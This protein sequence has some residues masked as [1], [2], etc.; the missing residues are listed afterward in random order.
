[1]RVRSVVG[2]VNH[3]E[4]IPP[5]TMSA[6]ARFWPWTSGHDT[7]EGMTKDDA[8]FQLDA[9]E[10][11]VLQRWKHTKTGTVYTVVAL[12]IAE[13]TLT[14]SVVYAGHDGVVWVRDLTVFLGNTDDGRP[15]FIL[16]TDDM[17]PPRRCCLASAT[18][19]HHHA[20][21]C[22]RKRGWQAAD[23]FE[24]RPA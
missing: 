16:V 1:M 21:D 5:I 8:L 10:V 12:G 18:P 17:M 6:F 24:E 7:G 23:G 9:S 20:L 3:S 14:P 15:R 4:I 11:R 22:T 13:A 2:A 19:P